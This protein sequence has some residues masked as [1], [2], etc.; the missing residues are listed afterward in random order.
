VEDS[1][2]FPPETACIDATK[3]D[4]PSFLFETLLSPVIADD[5]QEEARE[6]GYYFAK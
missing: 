5:M 4:G 3:I 1:G 2:G 6:F